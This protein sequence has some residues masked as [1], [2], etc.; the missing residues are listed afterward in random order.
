MP[1]S[2]IFCPKNISLKAL[3]LNLYQMLH[4]TSE[5]SDAD[6]FARDGSTVSC[7]NYIVR[8]G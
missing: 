8:T 4:L 3:M 5:V 6:C 2:L 1:Q 7:Q